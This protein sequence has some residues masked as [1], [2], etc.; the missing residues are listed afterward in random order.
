MQNPQAAASADHPENQHEQEADKISGVEVIREFLR[1]GRDAYPHLPLSPEP[2]GN[3]RWH[4]FG[5]GN[6]ESEEKS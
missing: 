4:F 2:P 5:A 6:D 3:I 1:T